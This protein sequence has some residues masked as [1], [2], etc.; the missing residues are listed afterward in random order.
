ML[1]ITIR[2]DP[3]SIIVL[4]FLDLKFWNN[5]V[6]ENVKGNEH[7]SWDIQQNF[8]KTLLL[9][10][11]ESKPYGFGKTSHFSCSRAL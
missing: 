10:A 7:S 8:C 11:N 1:N 6:L 4:V 3:K 2:T 9:L 5:T